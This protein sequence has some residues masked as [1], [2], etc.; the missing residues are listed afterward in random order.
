MKKK[1]LALLT[2]MLVIILS[3]CAGAQAQDADDSLEQEFSE[4]SINITAAEA[5]D[6]AIDL[7][8]GGELVRLELITHEGN[9]VFELNINFEDFLY[10]VTVDLQTGNVIHLSSDRL[11]LASEMDIPEDNENL[12]DDEETRHSDSSSHQSEEST[13]QTTSQQQTPPSSADSSSNSSISRDRAAEIALALVPGTLIEVDSD[14]EHGRAVWYVAIRSGRHI[15][16]I[17]VDQQTGEIVYHE[18]E[19]DD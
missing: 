13:T 9:R 5:E 11:L 19:I 14:F 6:L 1:I 12:E 3:A 17:Y 16:E 8:G 4:A 18:S 7:I 2:L 15:H 10:D